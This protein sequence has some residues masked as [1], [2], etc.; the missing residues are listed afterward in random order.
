[1][2]FTRAEALLNQSSAWQ[3]VTCC[4]PVQS[5]PSRLPRER[6]E[7]EGPI[8]LYIRRSSEWHAPRELARAGHS[9]PAG[10]K[11]LVVLHHTFRPHRPCGDALSQERSD[12]RGV[13]RYHR[14]QKWGGIGYHYAGFQSGN[15]YQCRPVTRTGAHTEGQNSKS[16]GY[17]LFID[18]DVH[19]PTAAAIETFQDWLRSVVASGVLEDSFDVRPHSD[20]ADKSCPGKRVTPL[21]PKLLPTANRPLLRVGDRGE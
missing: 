20:F 8:M 5:G 17:V 15:L 16:I 19:V 9:M 4:K 12:L 18:G 6:G 2:R 21:I 11:R 13:D 7:V 3:L 10:A 14:E 1:M